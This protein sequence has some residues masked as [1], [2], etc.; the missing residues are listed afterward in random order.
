VG[1]PVSRTERVEQLLSVKDL[2]RVLQVP[3][4]TIYQWRHRGE[5]PPPIRVGRHLRFDPADVSAWIEVR[6]VGSSPGRG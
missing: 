2:S 5:G 3:V 4:S 6:K 1:T